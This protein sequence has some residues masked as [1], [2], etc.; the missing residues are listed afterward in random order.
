MGKITGK[1]IKKIAEKVLKGDKRISYRPADDLEPEYDKLKE[2]VV[3]KGY[4]T[5]EEDVLSYASFPEVAEN[6]FK[7][8]KA[9]NEGV[10]SDMAKSGVYPV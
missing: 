3:A 5:Q 6:F 10:D 7:W 1:I 9:K 4:Y 2:E 8:R